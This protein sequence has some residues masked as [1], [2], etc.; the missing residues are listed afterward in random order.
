M[1]AVWT[2][3]SSRSYAEGVYVGLLTTNSIARWLADRLETVTLVESEPIKAVLEFTEPQDFAKQHVARG[4]TAAMALDQLSRAIP[5][6]LTP[7]ALI[8]TQ[9]GKPNESPLSVLV[10]ADVPALNAGL[11]P[12]TNR[13]R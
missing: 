7:A 4:V 9:N 8:V 11:A 10:A 6:G 12:G 3:H 13:H 2:T 5:S 1:C